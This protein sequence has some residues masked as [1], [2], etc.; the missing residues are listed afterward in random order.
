MNFQEAGCPIRARSFLARSLRKGGI[1]RRHG[2]LVFLFLLA[3]CFALHAETPMVILIFDF[4][5]SEPEHFATLV[6]A[7]CFT[8]YDSNGRLT[9]QSDAGEPFHLEFAMSKA[10]C[11]RIFSLAK[12]AQYFE[13]DI[14]SKAPNLA[15]T[16]HKTLVYQDG[17]KKTQATYNYSPIPAVEELTVLFQDLS[18]T[19]EFGRRLDFYHHYQKLMLDG[20]LERMESMLHDKSLEE[21]PAVAPILRTV[22]NDPSVMNISRRRA[23]RLLSQAG[24]AAGH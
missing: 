12:K 23:L 22:A 8:S 24:G 16:G 6:R 14:D 9:P 10:T 11:D 20:E 3:A 18:T 19:L 5:G 2:A 21:L 17:P 15:F 13:G 7:D 4:P 1:P